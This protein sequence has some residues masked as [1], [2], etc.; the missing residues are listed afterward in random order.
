MKS[1]TSHEG[2]LLVDHRDS[3]GIPEPLATASGLPVGAGRGVFEAA[4]Y[5]CNHCCRVVVINPLRNRERAYCGQCDHY[6]CD[7]CG[8]VKVITGACRSMQQIIE[9]TQEAA[10][11]S[12]A[13]I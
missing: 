9:E 1:K 8:A 6:I 11:S 5:T 10:I 7:Q 2:Y 4:T 13:I 3:P 12:L